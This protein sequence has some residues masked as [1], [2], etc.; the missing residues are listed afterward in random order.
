MSTRGASTMGLST[1][2]DNY[3]SQALYERFG[4]Q[5]AGSYVLYGKWAT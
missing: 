5:R 1:Q 2:K 4:F 3:R